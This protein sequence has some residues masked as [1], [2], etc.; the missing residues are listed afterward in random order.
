M[1]HVEVCPFTDS[2]VVQLFLCSL[3]WEMTVLEKKSA[4]FFPPTLHPLTSARTQMSG[5][6]ADGN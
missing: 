2:S 6:E 5:Q 3:Q 1:T 4:H